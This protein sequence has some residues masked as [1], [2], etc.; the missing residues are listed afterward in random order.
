MKILETLLKSQQYIDKFNEAGAQVKASLAGKRKDADPAG[1]GYFF[2]SWKDEFWGAKTLSEVE[3]QE[4]QFKCEAVRYMLELITDEEGYFDSKRRQVLIDYVRSM[5]LEFAIGMDIA[6]NK[7]YKK[8]FANDTLNVLEMN[9]EFSFKVYKY[10]A[11]GGMLYTAEQRCRR[12]GEKKVVYV[13]RLTEFED[14]AE[15]LYGDGFKIVTDHANSERTKATR[16]A[17][18]ARRKALEEQRLAE[19]QAAMEAAQ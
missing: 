7:S 8:E 12:N 5:G 13:M 17:R 11:R 1:E 10:G 14:R 3:L 4:F 6:G 2:K 9:S 15:N 19:R 16:A 18:E